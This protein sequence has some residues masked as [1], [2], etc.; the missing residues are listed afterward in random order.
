[1]KKYIFLSVYAFTVLSAEIMEI[2]YFPKQPLYHVIMLLVLSFVFVTSI[3]LVVD[4]K[5]KSYSVRYVVRYNG[6]KDIYGTYRSNRVAK[7]W[8]NLLNKRYKSN[9]KRYWYIDIDIQKQK[10]RST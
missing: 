1:M 8:C 9:N 4:Y 7:F 10:V 5:K 6:T 2:V 3:I